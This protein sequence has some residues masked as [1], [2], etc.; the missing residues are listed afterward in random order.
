MK[1]VSFALVLTLVLASVSTSA[2]AGEVLTFFSATAPTQYEDGNYIGPDDEIQYMIY[3]GLNS[4]VYT[5]GIST[6][7]AF[8]NGGEDLDVGFCVTSIGTYYFAA[9]SWSVL[10]G[11]ESI[12]SNE[13][14]RTYIVD[15]LPGTPMAPVL[16]SVGP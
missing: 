8:V 12:K 10:H 14:T 1:R 9:T 13:V 3:C 6:T 5:A 2:Y 4:G 11:T 15:D 7:E 16:L